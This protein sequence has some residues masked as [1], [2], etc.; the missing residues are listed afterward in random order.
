MYIKE[1][2]SYFATILF[3]LQYIRMT[4]DYVKKCNYQFVSNARNRCY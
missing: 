4:T 3:V 1:K 2:N